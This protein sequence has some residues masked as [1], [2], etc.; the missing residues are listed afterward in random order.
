MTSSRYSSVAIILHWVI[1]ALILSQAAGG[2]YMS[3]LGDSSSSKFALY[4]VHKSVG[5]FILLL[6][7]VRLGWRVTHRRV[8]LP[9]TMSPALK[10][11]AH[12][13]HILLYGFMISVPLIGWAMISASPAEIDTRFF[14]LFSWPHLPF[15]APSEAGEHFYATAHEVLAFAMIGLVVLHIAAAFKHMLFDKDGV[16]RSIA[17]LSFAQIGGVAVVL[18]GAGRSRWFVF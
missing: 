6:S 4:Q 18:L 17:P 15:I 5:L 14:G 9:S 7:V 11:V 2:I 13:T 3:G 12:V 8:A 1:A 16:M 10:L